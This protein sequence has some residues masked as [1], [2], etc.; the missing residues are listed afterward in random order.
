LVTDHISFNQV[1]YEYSFCCWQIGHKV[2]MKSACALCDEQLVTTKQPYGGE[3][4]LLGVGLPQFPNVDQEFTLIHHQDGFP[5]WDPM[6]KG[7]FLLCGFITNF[8]LGRL[9]L[10]LWA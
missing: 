10:V 9:C 3:N 6:R 2:K 4:S 1:K 7:K 8:F 5:M